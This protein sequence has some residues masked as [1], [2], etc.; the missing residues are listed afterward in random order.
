MLL[1]DFSGKNVKLTIDDTKENCKGDDCYIEII[2]QSSFLRE[3][4][5]SSILLSGDSNDLKTPLTS[6][7][8]QVLENLAEGKNNE[9]IAKCLNVS[10]HTTK[11]HIRNIFYKIGVQDRTEAVVKAIKNNWINIYDK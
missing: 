5:I 8:K 1:D 2:I 11:V 4:I 9:Q 3:L 7:E 6:R 10:V